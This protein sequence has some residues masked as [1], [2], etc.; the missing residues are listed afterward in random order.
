[1][2]SRILA[3]SCCLMLVG[4]A[5]ATPPSL[6]TTAA[7]PASS[8]V[9]AL[10]PENTSSR[11]AAPAIPIGL[12]HLAK[13]SQAPDGTPAHAR[14]L[15]KTRLVQIEIISRVAS[16]SSK[17]NWPCPYQ[18]TGVLG[19]FEYQGRLMTPFIPLGLLI[20]PSSSTQATVHY[21][22]NNSAWKQKIVN[23]APGA[24]III[25]G[26]ESRNALKLKIGI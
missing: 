9:S 22:T 21:S 1:M 26:S 20:V 24:E 7:Q 14:N 13:C 18:Y 12:A 5:S 19:G 8:S 6:S 11:P 4:A 2:K 3:T 23:L 10:S 25:D 17:W 16:S 15:P